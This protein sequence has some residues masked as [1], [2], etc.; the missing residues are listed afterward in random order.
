MKAVYLAELSG[1]E[2]LIFGEIADPSPK[3]GEIRV[4]VHAAALTPTEFSWSPTFKTRDGGPRPFP[5]VLGHEFSGLVNAIGDGA[6]GLNVGDEVYG[7]N[8]WFINGAQAEYCTAPVDAVALKPIELDHVEAAATP[9]SVL[10]SWQGLFEHGKL[11][12][13]ERVLIHGGSGGV[14]LFAVQ[15]AHWRGAY[16]IATASSRNSDFVRELG[17]DKVIDYK[18]TAFEKAV[19]DIDVVFDT[20]GGETLERSWSVLGPNG[21]MVTVAV[22]TEET[23]QRARDAFFIVEPNRTQLTEVTR[24]LNSGIIRVFVDSVFPLEQAGNGY[25]RAQQGGKRGKVVLQVKK[26]AQS[27]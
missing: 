22:Q 10:T 7:M 13:G 3:N 15:L 14:G 2:G 23:S 12:A 6:H 4:Q 19:R 11:K 26:G 21:R 8:D 9:I 5:I 25:A 1:P 17:A 20:V 16:V 18:T 27:S 24:L